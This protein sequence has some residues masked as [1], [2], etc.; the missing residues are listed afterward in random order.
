MPPK[1]FYIY[2]LICKNCNILPHC[3]QRTESRLD[4]RKFLPLEDSLLTKTC[5]RVAPSEHK[6]PFLSVLD[7]DLSPAMYAVVYATIISLGLLVISADKD[8]CDL[9]GAV[10]QSI[11]LPFVYNQLA[12]TDVLSWT[13]NGTLVFTR[14]RAK[15]LAGKPEDVSKTGSLLLKN[16]KRSSG[17]WYQATVRHP[18]H[19]LVTMWTGRLCTLDKV[20]QPRIVYICD[21]KNVFVNLSC[22]VDNPQDCTFSWTVDGINFPGATKQTLN[23]SL[24]GAKNFVC[25]AMNKFS[26]EKSQAVRP[27]CQNLA[28]TSMAPVLLCFTF[29]TI[30]TA[31]AG[32]TALFLLLLVV[33]AAMCRR[34]G[35]GKSD[36][37][38]SGKGDIKMVSVRK[39]T[40]ESNGPDYETM[41][42]AGFPT[43]T[44]LAPSPQILHPSKGLPQMDQAAARDPSP[45]PKPRTKNPQTPQL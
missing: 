16:L 9:Y 8:S 36:T 34:L 44:V 17:G 26:M 7:R 18:N 22:Q 27:V 12:N 11:E 39:Q 32:G 31:L 40:A 19:T 33:I 21:P 42:P 23:V 14:E 13:H 43:A 37:R 4:Q 38:V 20:S 30:I 28:P 10:G 25:R 6:D 2:S 15:V 35:R 3:H 1:K 29:K 45:V 24:G 5:T 41:N